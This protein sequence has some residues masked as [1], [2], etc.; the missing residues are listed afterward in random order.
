[1]AQRRRS[2]FSRTDRASRVCIGFFERSFLSDKSRGRLYWF[3]GRPNESSKQKRFF[4]ARS[5]VMQTHTSIQET[6]TCPVIPSDF[7]K[8]RCR[9]DRAGLTYYSS[10]KESS[11]SGP[12]SSLCYFGVTLFS[13]PILTY[14]TYHSE[15]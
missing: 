13:T 3:R 5:A 11:A 15:V 14:P 10:C 9:E 7:M 12:K 6:Y 1:M 4:P 2:N 8:R